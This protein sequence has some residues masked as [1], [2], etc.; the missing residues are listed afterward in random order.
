MKINLEQPIAYG[1]TAEIYPWPNG[2]VLKLFYDWFGLENIEYELRIAKAVHTS[3]LP[4]PAVGEIIQV[5]DRHGLIYQRVEGVSMFEVMSQKP[6]RLFHYARRSAELH[7]EMHAKT[8]Q[9]DIPEQHHKLRNKIK[10][11]DVLRSELRNRAFSALESMPG[12]D[13]LCHG[14]F[15][16]GNI[17]VTD[18][19]EVVID[20]IDSSLG[21][22]LSDLARSTII[23]LGA[24]ES[25]QIQYPLQK[26]AIRIF[27]TAYT[28]HYFSLRPGGEDKYA[29]WLPIVAA[30]R[31]SENISNLEQWLT[32]Q[33][34]KIF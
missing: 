28:R 22:P 19:D 33:V 23:A 32:T 2:K 16:P 3:G 25:D 6:W 9:A 30:A 4:V 14:D 8:I 29:R 12:G 34:E 1:R 24:V 13:R 21:N 17:M 31:L 10:H 20:W 27:H 26:L 7:V 11:A 5:N 15:H 18:Q